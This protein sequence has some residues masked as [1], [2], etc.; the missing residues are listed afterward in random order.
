MGAGADAGGIEAGEAGGVARAG[1]IT[2]VNS[3]GP[4]GVA[5]TMPGAGDNVCRGSTLS[6][7]EPGAA[8]GVGNCSV[9]GGAASGVP[10]AAGDPPPIGAAPPK[11]RVNSPGVFCDGEPIGSG[12]LEAS[13]DGASGFR[14]SLVNSPG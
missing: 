5:G 11:I 14:N 8:T 10:A 2:R 12:S 7:K 9:R 6:V 3:P 4:A 13:D 1:P